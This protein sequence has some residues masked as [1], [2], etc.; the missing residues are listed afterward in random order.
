MEEESMLASQL[1]IVCNENG[2]LCGVIKPGGSAIDETNLKKCI[3]HATKR[4]SS[5]LK[6]LQ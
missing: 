1:T 3:E 2:D 4:V 6:L 5:V